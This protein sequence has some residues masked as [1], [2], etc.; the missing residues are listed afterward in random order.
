MRC[1]VRRFHAMK[2]TSGIRFTANV[3]PD[4]SVIE[5]GTTSRGK[6][7]RRSSEPRATIDVRVVVVASMKK[8]QRTIPVSR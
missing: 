5:I 2:T 3:I 1:G 8:V 6:E 7:S 4:V